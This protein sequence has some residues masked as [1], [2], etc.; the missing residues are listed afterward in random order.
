MKTSFEKFMNS[1]AVE[2]I[3]KVELGAMKVELGENAQRDQI[4]LS[5]MRLRPP[6]TRLHCVVRRAI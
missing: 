1:T 3:S 4:Q 6:L 5:V 2:E